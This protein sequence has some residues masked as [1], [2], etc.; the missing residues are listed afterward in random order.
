[1]FYDFY[2]GYLVHGQSL[3]TIDGS[4]L[5]KR[6]IVNLAIIIP[7]TAF[8]NLCVGKHWFKRCKF[9]WLIMN[10][11]YLITFAHSNTLLF[12]EFETLCR[13][14]L[15]LSAM[16]VFVFAHLTLGG[17]FIED[18]VFGDLGTNYG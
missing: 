5:I 4:F 18:M 13:G 10:F 12:N 7:L 11:E 1:V 8:T 16:L 14:S 2:H 17:D 3:L 9:L 6:T 15:L